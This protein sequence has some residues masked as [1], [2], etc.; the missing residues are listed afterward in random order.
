MTFRPLAASTLLACAL[1]LPQATFAQETTGEPP[2]PAL[3]EPYRVTTHQ[4]WEILCTRFE[5]DG[6]ELCEMYQLLLNEDDS[7]VAEI[8]V[9]VLPPEEEYP[10][11][12]TVTTP[13]GTFLMPGMG[14]QIGDDGEIRAEPFQVCNA[15]GCMALLGL[16]DA[17]VQAMRS[18]SHAN[19]LFRPFSNPQGIARARVSLMGFTAALEDLQARAPMPLGA[20]PVPD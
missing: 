18:G 8:T 11:G 17:D 14:W 6:P 7:P 16:D 15:V 3:G 1:M 13:L 20:T 12:A 5:E 10:V 19:V 4:D 2:G 9:A